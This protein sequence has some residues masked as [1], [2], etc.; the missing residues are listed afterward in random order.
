MNVILIEDEIP[1]AQH[2]RRLLNKI[3]PEI[4]I[5]SEIQ[6]VRDAKQILPM[7]NADLIFLDI[8]LAD[9][10]SFKIFEDITIS[11]PIIFTTAYDQYAIDAFKLN[12][13]DYLLKPIAEQQLRK[14]L[15]KFHTLYYEKNDHHLTYQK[16]LTDIHSQTAIKSRFVVQNGSKLRTIKTSEVAMFNTIEK[17][18]FLTTFENRTFDIEYSLDK[19]ENIVESKQFFRIN[20]QFIINIDAIEDVV[21]LSNTHLKLKLKV[22]LDTPPTVSIRRLKNFKDWLNQ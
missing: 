10:T 7:L 16:L 2:M 20:R 22:K 15:D 21:F 19:L 5:I 3:N 4:A 13:I 12:S 14:A 1:A 17:N 8:H 11:T 18:T 9:D 6:T